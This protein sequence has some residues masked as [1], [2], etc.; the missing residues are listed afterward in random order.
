MLICKNIMTTNVISVMENADVYTAARLM[1]EN[2]I[3]GIPVTKNDMTLAGI[4]TEK[5]IIR[6]L[7]YNIEQSRKVENF[8]TKNVI[9]FDQEDSLWEVIY[10]LLKNRFRRVP[11]L[12]KGKLVGIISRKDIISH[13]YRSRCP[14]QANKAGHFCE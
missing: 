13:I 11:I 9:A 2:N 7:Y 5:D 14:A 4:V 1:A 3:T 10:C 12:N 6:L 8:M